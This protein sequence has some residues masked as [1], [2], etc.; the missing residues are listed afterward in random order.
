MTY[1]ETAAWLRP[2]LWIGVV[3]GII[4]WLGWFASLA[5][6]G[7]YKDAEGTLVGAD[8]L[9]FYT[10]AHL[11]RNGQQKKI[12]DYGDLGGYQNSLIGWEWHGFEAYR[13]PPF[14]ALLYLPTANF[15][16][17]A[18]FL[19]WTAVSAALLLLSIRLLS[20]QTRSQVL[21]WSL[22][23]YPL[24]A[25]I[26]F[27]Q[28]SLISLAI[29]A[30]VYRL[31]EDRRHFLAGVVAGLLF[32]KPQLL[33]G[34]FIWWAFSPRQY[35]H[36]WLGVAVSGAALACVSWGVLPEASQ[37]FVDNRNAIVGYG[38]FGLWNVHTP[39]AFFQLLLNNLAPP[40]FEDEPA[41]SL[42]IWLLTLTVVLVSIAI[43]W[44]VSRQSRG[45][46]A[47]MFPT[48]VFLSLWASP[49]TLIYEWSLLIAACAVLWEKFPE[50]RDKWRCLFVAAWIGLSI[51][52]TIAFLQIRFLHLP[53]VLQLSV[54]I[55]GITGWLTARELSVARSLN[56]QK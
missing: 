27:G 52:T 39:R 31:L 47:T 2:R 41:K 25:T 1:A 56:E 20:F 26:S 30:G 24:F 3:V 36:S 29:F 40:Y 53:V 32:Y 48:A 35:F 43:A 38:G 49:H 34:L 45:S 12:Y 11:I 9:A 42:L 5:I 6:G 54:P 4:P 33:V 44:R 21:F 37:A 46:V 17:Y 55:L 19:I 18:S 13:N 23:F 8:H 10:A 28:N 16:F 15:S 7:W 22:L 51:S 50:S 14:Y